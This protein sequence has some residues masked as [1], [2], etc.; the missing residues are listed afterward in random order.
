MNNQEAEA[1]F[2]ALMDRI[3]RKDPSLFDEVRRAVD[4]G[5]ETTI[6]QVPD[7]DTNGDL[8]EYSSRSGSPKK[9][10]T[11][12]ARNPYSHREALQVALG[13][14]RTYFLE[15]PLLAMSIAENL[16]EASEIE[17]DL[18]VETQISG[19]DNKSHSL[20]R[21]PKKQIEEQKEYLNALE[22]LATFAEDQP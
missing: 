7:D 19:I 8:F 15:L 2:D 21:I 10:H 11:Y 1:A 3:R 13:V 12:R 22:E 16:G 14:L 6:G 20:K 4:A 18:Q 17:I 9:P 5:K